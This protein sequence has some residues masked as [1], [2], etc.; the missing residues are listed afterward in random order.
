MFVLGGVE[1]FAQNAV[2]QVDDF[3][4]DG[5]HAFDG[6]RNQSRVAALRLELG[7]VGWRHLATLAG[8]LEQT[9]LVNLP[10]DANR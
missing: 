8:D 10:F 2:V 5:R 4:S 6:E 3:V 1:Q 9:V 7:Q